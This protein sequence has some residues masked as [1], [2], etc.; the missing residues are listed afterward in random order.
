MQTNLFE[1]F[2]NVIDAFDG[3]WNLSM[4]V[5]RVALFSRK[6]QSAARLFNN[7]KH[8]STSSL[9]LSHFNNDKNKNSS[10]N[11]S[12]LWISSLKNCLKLLRDQVR[13]SFRIEWRQ[14]SLP[15]GRRLSESQK[16]INLLFKNGHSNWISISGENWIPGKHFGVRK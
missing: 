3:L 12:A 8:F 5:G 14:E 15:V 11:D 16:I 2:K 4:F 9:R 1:V 7:F 6:V 10:K 13:S